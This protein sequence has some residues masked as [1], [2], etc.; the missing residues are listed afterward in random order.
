MP[1]EESEHAGHRYAVQFTS[2][3]PDDAWYV[4][5][6]EAVPAWLAYT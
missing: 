5:L 1:Y 3:L 6:S 4:E 2:A